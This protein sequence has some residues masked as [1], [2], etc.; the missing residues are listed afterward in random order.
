[1]DVRARVLEAVRRRARRSST[2]GWRPSPTTC[3]APAAPRVRR[4]LAAAG[5][6]RPGAARRARPLPRPRRRGA[7]RHRRGQRRGGRAPPR[8]QARARRHRHGADVVPGMRQ[9][10]VL[11][12]G[13]PV[14]WERMCGPMRGAV[15][16]GLLYEGLAQ[17]ARGGRGARRLGARS[18]FEPCHHHDAVGPMA[19]VVTASMPVWIVENAAFG[20]RA[21][22]TLNEGLGK[23]LRYGAYS[24]RGARAA[25]LDGATSGAGARRRRS[26][27]TGPL[28]LRASSPRRCRWATRGT[29]ATAPAPRCSSASWRRTWCATG[30]PRDAVAAVLASSNGNDHFFLNLSMPAGKCIARRRARAS[31]RSLDGHRHGAQRHRLRHPASSGLPATAGSPRRRRWCDGLY[32]PGLQ[33]RRRR[34]RHRRLGRSPRPP[35][36]GGFAMAAAPAIVQFVGGSAARRAR[37]YTRRCT[38][39]TLGREPGL[40]A[41]RPSTS[42]ARRPA[43]TCCKVVETGILPVDQHRHRPQ[44]ARRRHGRRRAGQA[45]LECFQRRACARS[46]SHVGRTGPDARADTEETH[47]AHRS[48]H[49]PRHRH[50]ALADLRAAADEVLQAPRAQR[51]QRPG[52]HPLEPPRHAPRRRDPLL[53]AGQG[54]RRARPRLP[55]ARG[56]RSSTSPTSPATTT[57]TPRRWS[58][59]GSR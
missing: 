31:P 22:C 33:R 34:P 45:A 47:E 48:H 1:M 56:R 50:P 14:T 57:S 46:P 59:S 3:A 40:H 30:E 38:S 28:D 23:V 53:H 29:T 49:P 4:G 51:R 8:G 32:L 39:I 21:Y 20:N 13:P 15:I 37:D 35:G 54:H 10:L 43:S 6:R 52:A 44:G 55:G 26:R 42:A 24:R 7:R 41:S 18:T 2:S 16:G 58:R 12:A 27:R 25:A 9:D 36:I 5:R 17:D 11:H 19:G